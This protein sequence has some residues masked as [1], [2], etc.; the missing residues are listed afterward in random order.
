MSNKSDNIR[1]IIIE[2]EIECYPTNGKTELSIHIS[3]IEK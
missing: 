2:N 1:Y 3:Y